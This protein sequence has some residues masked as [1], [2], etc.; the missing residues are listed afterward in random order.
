MKKLIQYLMEQR[1]IVTLAVC[2][3]FA[4]GFIAIIHMNRESIR[5]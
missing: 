4:A 2:I 1:L 3:F 5:S